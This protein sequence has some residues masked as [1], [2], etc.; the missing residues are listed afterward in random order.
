MHTL[1]SKQR[2][3]WVSRPKTCGQVKIKRLIGCD[4]FSLCEIL[5]L[6]Y[7]TSSEEGIKNDVAYTPGHILSRRRCI[8][9]SLGQWKYGITCN[10]TMKLWFGAMIV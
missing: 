7:Q 6:T 5:P 2:C 1:V 10:P 8:N 4:C 9:L 3:S